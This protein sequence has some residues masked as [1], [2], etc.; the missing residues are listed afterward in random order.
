MST[1]INTPLPDGFVKKDI[2]VLFIEVI[3]LFNTI[4]VPLTPH[5]VLVPEHT[6]SCD[7][8]TGYNKFIATHLNTLSAKFENI[9][10]VREHKQK[11]HCVVFEL[12]ATGVTLSNKLVTDQPEQYLVYNQTLE[13]FVTIA[14]P[15]D[16]LD[17]HIRTHTGNRIEDATFFES[18]PRIQMMMDVFYP[19]H[20]YYVITIQK[21]PFS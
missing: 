2:G 18:M 12:N 3:T 20:E 8:V 11:H 6:T 15:T 1:L 21:A 7:F 17:H 5:Y 16:V 14:P 10:V 9:P 19:T 13:G 4:N